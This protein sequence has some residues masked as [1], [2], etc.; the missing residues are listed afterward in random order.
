MRGALGFNRG[1]IALIRRLNRL[2]FRGVFP[3]LRLK[4]RK[5][6]GAARIF[7]AVIVPCGADRRVVSVAKR[8]IGR[9]PD[10]L[11]AANRLVV[12]VGDGVERAKKRDVL[13]QIDPFA[14]ERR[15]RD[16]RNRRSAQN[17][18][19]ALRADGQLRA[20]VCRRFGRRLVIELL[21]RRRVRERVGLFG[22][23]VVKYPFRRRDKRFESDYLRDRRVPRQQ[24][25]RDFV[26]LIR[27]RGVNPRVNDRKTV[28]NPNV[29]FGE[30]EENRRTRD[31]AELV[32]RQGRVGR[33]VVIVIERD[34]QIRIRPGIVSNLQIGLVLDVVDKIQFERRRS[35]RRRGV[36][37]R[38]RDRLPALTRRTRRSVPEFV[39]DSDV[40]R[41]TRRRGV[42]REIV[43]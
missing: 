7:A 28:F 18:P 21:R 9:R 30:R 32:G 42:K 37:I 25:N 29:R 6:V 33:S 24:R 15:K 8:L 16:L 11:R 34:R 19:V 3:S 14:V 36:V 13:R 10:V 17:V 26:R 40:E 23:I 39:D 5:F 27:G 20:R 43:S 2:I 35:E 38:G 12:S 1:K 31:S 4:S 41:R 22:R